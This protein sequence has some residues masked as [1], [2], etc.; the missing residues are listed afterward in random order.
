MGPAGAFP[1]QQWLAFL[2][3]SYLSPPSVWIGLSPRDP[4]PALKTLCLFNIVAFF[5]G[6]LL[7]PPPWGSLALAALLA[8]GLSPAGWRGAIYD[9]W[10]LASGWA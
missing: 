6:L 9:L 2:P 7:P 10:G 4:M 5:N 1:V 3:L 8:L